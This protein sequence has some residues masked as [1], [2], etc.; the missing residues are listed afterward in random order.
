MSA[1]PTDEPIKTLRELV[2]SLKEQVRLLL[3]RFERREITSKEAEAE[4]ERLG[5]EIGDAERRVEQRAAERRPD[6]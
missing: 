5:R 4:A 3:E 2:A 1:K 6:R